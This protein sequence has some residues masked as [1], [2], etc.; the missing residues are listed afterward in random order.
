MNRSWPFRTI[1]PQNPA[2]HADNLL[3]HMQQKVVEA[4]PGPLSGS[5]WNRLPPLTPNRRRL[6]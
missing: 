5:E 6:L 3:L 2:A 1:A 4:D